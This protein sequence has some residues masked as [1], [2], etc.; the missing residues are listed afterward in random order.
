[1]RPLFEHPLFL[2]TTS[3]AGVGIGTAATGTRTTTA[4][5]FIVPGSSTICGADDIA[6]MISS[7]DAALFV[8]AAS[9]CTG[10]SMVSSSNCIMATSGVGADDSSGACRGGGDTGGE[11]IRCVGANGG[12][13]G[14][15]RM[16]KRDGD[17]DDDDDDDD[18]NDDD[19]DDGW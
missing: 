2:G 6:G 4:A 8:V 10:A 12:E 16:V 15:I 7:S 9:I 19:N 3:S 5:L 14:M 17:D 18:D 13:D 11:G 1:M